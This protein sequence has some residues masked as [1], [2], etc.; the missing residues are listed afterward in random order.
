M[1]SALIQSSLAPQGHEDETTLDIPT[2]AKQ[3]K[4]NSAF[5]AVGQRKPETR[6]PPSATLIIAPT[7]LLNQWFEEL[8]RSSKPGTF[9][10]IVWHGQNRL[11]LEDLIEQNSDDKTIKV[12]IT[13]YGVLAS[14]HAKMEKS[15]SY[16]SPVF[17][18]GLVPLMPFP[19]DVLHFQSIGSGLSLTRPML[20]NHVLVKRLRLYMHSP[21]DGDGL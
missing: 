15:G 5:R 2:K 8:E 19:P 14:E 20:V 11:D 7:S 6:K 9:D 10:A 17:E 12:V 18:S 21:Q 16:K 1:L 3:L 13:S 4:L